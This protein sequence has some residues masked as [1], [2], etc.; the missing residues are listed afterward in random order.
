[1]RRTSSSALR[2]LCCGL[3]ALTSASWC[4]A[5]TAAGVLGET[6]FAEG[7]RRVMV[8]GHR[9]GGFFAP[10]NTLAAIDLAIEV[11]CDG[12]ELD[13][14]RTRD[15]HFVLMH[16]S[17]VDRTTDGRGAIAEMTLA[18][19]RKLKIRWT[20]QSFLKKSQFPVPP[21]DRR[22]Q[23]LSVP[24]LKNA[25]DRARGRV[26]VVL[27]LKQADAADVARLVSQ[28]DLLG[29]V[30]FKV[31]SLTEGQSVRAAAP[32]VCLMARAYNQEELRHMVDELKPRVAHL[33]EETFVRDI[34][35]EM[36][37]TGIKIWINAL[38]RIDVQAV[39]AE[40]RASHWFERVEGHLGGFFVRS[41]D[42]QIAPYRE[43]ARRG[44]DVIQTD[45]IVC[46]VEGMREF[47]RPL[48][49]H[50]D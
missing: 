12:V 33:D 24:T 17:T 41:F 31:N 34:I 4:A 9:G 37:E 22:F 46:V 16:D 25:L 18:E 43:L 42:P 10:E 19:V 47:R 20:P 3:V 28:S 27:D 13:V 49:P 14:Q 23:D 2:A 15:G 26:F 36:Q 11:G 7:Q 48:P 40:G 6:L 35:E 45:N 39:L 5:T 38:G 8:V 29:D 30:I 1:M 50:P 21:G 32:Q 44:A